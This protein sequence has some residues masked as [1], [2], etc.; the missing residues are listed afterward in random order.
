MT[1]EV[2]KC[3]QDFCALFHGYDKLQNASRLGCA[4][5]FHM[6]AGNLD[7]AQRL[8]NLTRTQ[9]DDARVLI[10]PV[11]VFGRRILAGLE[12]TWRLTQFTVGQRAAAG[13][14]E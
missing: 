4:A 10:W 7:E 8:L 1:D 13:G 2:M 11:D 12:I 5:S 9:L 6:G 3:E 14:Q